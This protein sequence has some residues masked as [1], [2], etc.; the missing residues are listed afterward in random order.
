[1]KCEVIKIITR[2]SVEELGGI[3]ELIIKLA[4][5]I[6]RKNEE[7][8][9]FCVEDEIVELAKEVLKEASVKKDEK[10]ANRVHDIYSVYLLEKNPEAK[11]TYKLTEE[12]E[13]ENVNYINVKETFELMKNSIAFGDDE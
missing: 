9:K 12:F 11:S 6:K 4:E 1:M 5:D 10:T 7:N 2:Y 3:E 13:M 8:K